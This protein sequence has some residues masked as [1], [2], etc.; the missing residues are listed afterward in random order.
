MP[1]RAN[2]LLV[3]DQP[4]RL[5]TYEVILE[6]LDQNLVRALSGEEA[7]E[8]LHE[9]EFAAVLLDVS[10]PGMNGFETAALVRNHPRF[11][12]TPIIFVTGVH[13]TDLDRL[14]GYEMG[15]ADYVYVPVIPDVLRGKVQVL[16]QLY[17]QRR[18]LAQLNDRLAAA[19][20]E[21]AEAHSRLQAEN[22]REL[23]KLNR[24]LERA[25]AQLISE[26]ADRKHAETLLKEEARRKDEFISILGH[27]LRNP[28]AAM[29]SGI[30]LLRNGSPAESKLPWAR[31]LLQRQ[32]RHL[33]RLIDDL[34]DV[35]R[36]TS[37]RVQLQ[38]ETLDLKSVIEHSIDAVQPLIAERQHEVQVNLP[39]EPLYM[40]G[41]P[42][43]LTQ[44]F[45]NLLTNAAKYTEPGGTITLS[46]EIEPGP[47]RAVTVRV[48][49]TGAGIPE[50]ML[51]RVF[52]LFT[53]ADADATRTQTG[54]GIGLALVRAMA[55]LHGG[56]VHAASTGP[57]QGSEFVVRL[58]LLEEGAKRQVKPAAAA[59]AAPQSG[60]RLLIIDD[61]EDLAKGLSLYLTEQSG[62]EVRCAHTG[63]AGI[64]IAREF[65]PDV[66]L[67]DIGLPDID[68]Y[69]VARRLRA[70]EDLEEVPLIGISGFS[71]SADRKRAKRA[72]FDRY[73]VKPIA[74]DKLNDVLAG[75]LAP[76]ADRATAG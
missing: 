73:F 50:D 65:K 60:L 22:T 20:N 59:P 57:G 61:N 58:P 5:L 52:E 11:G 68:G 53:Q 44:V 10:M 8:K 13:I 46:T 45:G 19:N 36:I 2:I 14:R 21:L 43:R 41:D 40:D 17:L 37:G 1:E 71:T 33:K 34:L 42:V 4:E 16:V 38:R 54:L 55:D 66:V 70:E 29:Q 67:L 56:S 69:E 74:F 23:Q 75:Q 3:D 64:A 51:D 6:S 28:L 12:Q 26:V 7:F 31:E 76:A 15:A 62:H 72:G 48:R 49:D 35:T 47:P 9:R 32:L 18:E 24:T 63:E 30:E 27:E 39:P 25:N